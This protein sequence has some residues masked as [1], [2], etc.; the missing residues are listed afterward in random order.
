MNARTHAPWPVLVNRYARYVIVA[1]CAIAIAIA[2]AVNTGHAWGDHHVCDAAGVDHEFTTDADYHAFLDANPTAKEGAC[3]S[4]TTTAPASTVPPPTVA[5][6][7]TTGPATV[8]TPTDAAPAPSTTASPV[9]SPTP[10]APP[11]TSPPLVIDRPA[12]V[13]TGPALPDDCIGTGDGTWTTRWTLQPCTPDGQ[14]SA[15]PSPADDANPTTAS[16]PATPTGPATPATGRP[17]SPSA[18]PE[19]L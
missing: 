16:T 1:I 12:D 10:D 2:V 13:P 19:T 5:T 11:S 6:P 4:S 17:T 9:A 7:T 8:P 14:A 15:S 18:L 3:A